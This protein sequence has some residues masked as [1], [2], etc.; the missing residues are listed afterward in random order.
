MV[1]ASEIKLSGLRISAAT[2]SP[3]TLVVPTS[4]AEVNSCVALGETVKMDKSLDELE[5]QHILATLE[6]TN[7]NKSQTAAILGIERSTLD[8]KLK[9]YG[10][11][12]PD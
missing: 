1:S 11:N 7:W 6:K 5:Q 4:V 2:A 9:R 12:R 10:V 8:R 3:P